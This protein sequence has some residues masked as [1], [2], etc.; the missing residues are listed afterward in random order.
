MDDSKTTIQ[1]RFELLKKNL[2]IPLVNHIEIKT[3][4]AKSYVIYDIQ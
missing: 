2:T 1:D 4:H 3:N